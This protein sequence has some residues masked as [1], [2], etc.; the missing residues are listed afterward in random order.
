[1]LKIVICED[2]IEQQEILKAYLEKILN[3]ISTNYE[4]LFFYSG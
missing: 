3:Q 1:M 2:E 4:I